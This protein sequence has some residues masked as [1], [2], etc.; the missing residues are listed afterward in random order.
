M[1]RR[2]L[3]REQHMYWVSHIKSF[4][5]TTYCLDLRVTK[6]TASVRMDGPTTLKIWKQVNI[7]SSTCYILLFSIPFC[8]AVATNV[9]PILIS[10]TTCEV[11]VGTGWT[12]YY[13]TSVLHLL[14]WT[15]NMCL[16]RCSTAGIGHI[17]YVQEV[18]TQFL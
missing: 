3:E 7:S 5:Y 10:S 6:R 2:Y 17:L 13:R 14:Q 12:V 18:V 8:A 16:S 4:I 9:L 1:L 15:W 11:S